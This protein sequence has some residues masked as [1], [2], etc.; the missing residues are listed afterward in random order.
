MELRWNANK[1]FRDTVLRM[2]TG[3]IASQCVE[4]TFNDMKNSKQIKGKKKFRR[5]AKCMASVLARSVLSKV[6]SFDEVEVDC[7]PEQL[8]TVLPPNTFGP[9]WKD[10]PLPFKHIASNS[11]AAHW[12]SPGPG[13]WCTHYADMDV[14]NHCKGPPA[15]YQEVGHLW[16]G[17]FVQPTH[18]LLIKH[19]HN[20]K[21]LFP[22]HVFKD[23]VVMCLPALLERKKSGKTVW[24]SFVPEYDFAEPTRLCVC[25][26]FE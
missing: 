5:P 25:V 1:L 14:P 24:L 6:H 21:L 4:D 2:L 12:Y 9:V 3:M 26:E 10:A 8:T 7:Q 13:N 15:R 16:L 11:Q 18:K 19:K 23:S 17:E 22:V 20:N